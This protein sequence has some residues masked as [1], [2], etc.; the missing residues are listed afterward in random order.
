MS[1]ISKEELIK[2]FGNRLFNFATFESYYGFKFFYKS[3]DERFS[4]CVGGDVSSILDVSLQENMSLAAIASKIN[5]VSFFDY[6]VC[7]F[8]YTGK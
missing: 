5:I 4:L 2:K 1:E 7:E 8:L 6:D 3:S